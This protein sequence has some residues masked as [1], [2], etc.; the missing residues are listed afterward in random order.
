ML[1]VNVKSG[2]IDKALKMLK[3]KVRGTKQVIT[4]RNNK[5][6]TKPSEERRDKKRKAIYVD[7]KKREENND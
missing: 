2:N 7:N 4:L 3:N 5:N 1:K 6:Y